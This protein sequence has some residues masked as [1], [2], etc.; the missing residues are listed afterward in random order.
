MIEGGKIYTID[1]YG[2]NK[3]S[4][5]LIETGYSQAELAYILSRIGLL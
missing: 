1:K 2:G 3:T 5:A 4:I